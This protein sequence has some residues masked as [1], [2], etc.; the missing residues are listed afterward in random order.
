[1]TS[2]LYIVAPVTQ[3]PY[4]FLH[5][6]PPGKKRKSGPKYP[7][8]IGPQAKICPQSIRSHIGHVPRLS[9]VLLQRRELDTRRS[10]IFVK[11]PSGL[12]SRL[13]LPTILSGL[14][15]WALGSRI[16]YTDRYCV[17]ISTFF[18]RLAH[19]FGL[20][21]RPA[22]VPPSASPPESPVPQTSLSTISHTNSLD[23]SPAPRTGLSTSCR[24][25]FFAEC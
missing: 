17:Q 19:G 2:V 6:T 5:R 7:E 16:M 14:G 3:P 18:T 25:N 20:K 11:C 12:Q 21:Q 1:M 8:N 10:E 22:A 15:R 23:R 9:G 24:M 4:P 13:V